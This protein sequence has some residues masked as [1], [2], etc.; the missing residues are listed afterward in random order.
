MVDTKQW[1]VAAGNKKVGPLTRARVLERLSEGKV[2]ARALVWREGMDEWL[3]VTQVPELSEAP[4]DE[5]PERREAPRARKRLAGSGSG[6][7][8]GSGTGSGLRSRARRGEGLAFAAPH[9]FERA[10]M[11]RA[12]ALGLEGRRV[13]LAFGGGA[14][15]LLATA[16]VT[17]VTAIAGAIHPLLAIPVAL[18]G[19]LLSSAAG[20][21]VLGALAWHARQRLE[22]N[23][24]TV[25]AALAWALEHASAIAVPPLV[26]SVA[27][28]VPLV[29]LAFLALLAK[30]P[31]LGP[32]GT[33]VVYGVHLA[34]G[35]A[36]L[37]L[38]LCACMG[39]AFA[40][41]V[42]A[43]EGTGVK[44]TL[45][46]L[47]EF[48]RASAV[49][50]VLWALLPGATMIPFT[51]AVLVV[52]AL[53]LA[54]PLV[55]TAAALGPETFSWVRLGAQGDPPYPG[56]VAGAIPLG[57]WLVALFGLV[58]ALLGSV[59]TAL[60]SLLYAGGRTGNDDLPTRD[61]VLAHAVSNQ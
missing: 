14:L 58:L 59:Q 30:I 13:L 1:F 33:G 18:L 46:R 11:W 54:L 26:L 31:Y 52:A 20:S 28:L 9:R 48:V 47:M 3:P 40:P 8:I 49:R 34:L 38:L 7:G 43:F 45:A 21:L 50:V 53:I 57:L 36:T 10:D 5:V 60:V 29:G 41:V 51:A 44:E 42:A 25:R 32:I 4:A 17:G 22:G 12:F 19:G 39:G 16:L 15:A 6:S 35:A 61:A 27:W 2:P 23:Q 37:F 55:T 24:P 56:L